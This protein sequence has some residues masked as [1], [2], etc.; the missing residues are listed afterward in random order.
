MRWFPT[1]CLALL[2]AGLLLAQGHHP[3][4]RPAR[5][6]D[7]GQAHGHSRLIPPL[8]DALKDADADVRQSAAGALAAIGQEAVAPLLKV[9]EDKDKDKDTRAGIAFVFGQMGLQG[10]EALPA[11]TKSLKDKEEDKDVRRKAVAAIALIVKD[12]TSRGYGTGYGYPP[13]YGPMTPT[14][15]G[16]PGRFVPGPPAL[17]V[18]A[19]PPAVLPERKPDRRRTT[20]EPQRAGL[21]FRPPS[22]ALLAPSARALQSFR[23]VAVHGNAARTGRRT[24]MLHHPRTALLTFARSASPPPPVI[25][26]GSPLDD[27]TLRK[28]RE[29]HGQEL[30]LELGDA[31]QMQKILAQR[32]RRAQTSAGAKLIQDAVKNPEKYGFSPE[33]RAPRTGRRE[34]QWRPSRDA[35]H[36]SRSRQDV[37]DKQGKNP[38][39]T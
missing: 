6:S 33:Q 18:P 12:M 22:F 14:A 23:W 2:A 16:I 34:G 24:T 8:L 13:P 5:L 28:V 7:A 35:T 19:D 4:E 36:A 37:L 27:L 11:L 21:Q 39:P 9:F 30:G 1:C 17:P 10:R 3:S 32:L 25:R 38:D 29:S 20:G 31:E 26:P 15:P